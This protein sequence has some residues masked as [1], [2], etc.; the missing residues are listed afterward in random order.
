[1]SGEGTVTLSQKGVPLKGELTAAARDDGQVRLDVSAPG[2]QVMFLLATNHETMTVLDFKNRQAQRA[3]AAGTS[4]AGL[5]IDGFTSNALAQLLL[6]RLPCAERREVVALNTVR[7]AGCLGDMMTATYTPRQNGGGYYLTRMVI[8]RAG[9]DATATLQAQTAAG[10]PRRI[11]IE[12]SAGRAI[13]ALSDIDNNPALPD[14]LFTVA[15]PAG[16]AP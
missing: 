13:V 2:G 3:P 1:M 12:T 15:I 14:S 10:L 6:A 5:G 11:E 7:V 9:G 16:F 4:L 8:H